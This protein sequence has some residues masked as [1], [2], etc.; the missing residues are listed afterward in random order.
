MICQFVGGYSFRQQLPCTPIYSN[1]ETVII[2]LY[3]FKQYEPFQL[4]LLSIGI[5][6]FNGT[7][8][9]TEISKAREI[10]FNKA[11]EKAE[12]EANIICK[13]LGRKLGKVLEVESN[14]RDYV[15]TSSIQA[16]QSGVVVQDRN[17]VDIPQY[18]T[19]NTN[20]K[21]KFELK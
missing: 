9:T 14:N 15:A 1:G 17:L 20:L 16:L 3:D 2:K 18:V 11:I 13:K 4:D 19:L 6:N 10:G 8:S 21:I 5:Y 12:K 7:F